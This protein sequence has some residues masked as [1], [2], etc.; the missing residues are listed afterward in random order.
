MEN[1]ALSNPLALSLKV[2]DN[3]IVGV[4]TDEAV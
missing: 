3:Q 4:R 2:V 1:R